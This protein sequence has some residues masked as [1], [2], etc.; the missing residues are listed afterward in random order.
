MTLQNTLSL[1]IETFAVESARTIGFHD[2]L[3]QKTNEAI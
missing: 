1:M 3:S 2:S